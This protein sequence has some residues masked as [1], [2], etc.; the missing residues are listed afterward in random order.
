MSKAKE[1]VRRFIETID[2][3]GKVEWARKTRLSTTELQQG[4]Y[5]LY[6]PFAKRRNIHNCPIFSDGSL[7][8]GTTCT[9]VVTLPVTL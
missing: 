6:L 8:R 5:K 2:K 9:L 4:W 3:G 1:T 7:K